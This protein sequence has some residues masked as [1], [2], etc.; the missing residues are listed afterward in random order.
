VVST[1]LKFD[2]DGIPAIPPPTASF[3]GAAFPGLAKKDMTESRESS[4]EY[5]RVGARSPRGE[6]GGLIQWQFALEES[7]QLVNYSRMIRSMT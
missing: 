7:S 2:E 3:K 4:D 1:V 5:G 6:E